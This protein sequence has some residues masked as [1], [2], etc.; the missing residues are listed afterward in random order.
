MK[1]KYKLYLKL[2]IISL[3]FIVSSFIFTTLAWFAY[4]GLSEVSTEIDVKAWYIE[5]TKSGEKVSNNIVITLSEIY[6]GMNTIDEV[7]NIE[8]L[9]DSHAQLKYEIVSA[10]ILDDPDHNYIIDGYTSSE[11]VEDILAHN[12]P[13]HVNMNLSKDYIFASNDSSTF[14]VSVSWPLDSGS[15]ELDKLDSEWGTKAYKFQ[16]NEASLKKADKN[17]VVRPA[18][19]IVISVT[20][21][22]YIEND[23]NSSDMD[24]NLGDTILFDVVNNKKCNE[25]EGSCIKT[26]VI[27]KNNKIGDDFVTL[28]PNLYDIDTEGNRDNY[29]NLYNPL[30]SS[31]NVLTRPLTV[32][33]LLLVISNDITN[34]YLV[35]EKSS[36]IIIG[37]LL[38]EDRISNVVQKAIDLKGNFTFMNNKFNYLVSNNCF[39]T[40]T[41][42]DDSNYFALKKYDDTISK[43]YPVSSDTVCRIVP[44]IIASKKESLKSE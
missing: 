40:N 13:F 24:Y 43:I 44:V 6:P 3:V 9:G 37:R 18:I 42:Y 27:D 17:Y 30:V 14:E 41:K 38:T 29:E 36:N 19:Q 22:Q 28:L 10:R 4:S 21:E 7:V 39:W 20:A 32:D 31:W 25:L 12:F 15:Y 23:D 33:D 16:E 5:L 2:N 26:T 8:N 35:G 11:Y 34:S 1:Q